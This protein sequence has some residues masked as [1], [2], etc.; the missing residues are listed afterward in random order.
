MEE[1]IKMEGYIVYLYLSGDENGAYQ[2]Y[3]VEIAV[4]RGDE[5]AIDCNCADAG[6]KPFIYTILLR[7]ENQLLFR[8][9]WT[10]G[11]MMERIEGQCS[12]RL[13]QNGDRLCVAGVW[14]EGGETSHWFGEFTKRSDV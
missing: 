14:K 9:T 4:F 2:R 10:A 11:Q 3:R 6:E 5:L 7:R 12:C 13:Y 8:G 1:A